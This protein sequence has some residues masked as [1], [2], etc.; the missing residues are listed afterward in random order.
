V[1]IISISRRFELVRYEDVSGVS[2]T[3]T[4]ADGIQFPDG[5]VVLSW[6]GKHHCISVWP[7]VGEVEAIH[8]HEGKTVVRWIDGN[9]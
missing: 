4:V 9:N 7:N 6:R 1:G 3:G 5:Q 2:G 8:G